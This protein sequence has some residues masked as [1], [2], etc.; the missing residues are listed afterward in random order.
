LSIRADVPGWRNE[1]FFTWASRDAV[2][3]TS[4][5]SKRTPCVLDAIDQAFVTFTRVPNTPEAQ[6]LRAQ[7]LAIEATARQWAKVPP[8]GEEREAMARK[9]LALH[10]AITKLRR[11]SPPPVGQP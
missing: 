1:R 9:V 5:R 7:C 8:S 10:V 3:T 2:M 4:P 6:E 11:S